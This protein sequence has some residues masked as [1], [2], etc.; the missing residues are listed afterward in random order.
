MQLFSA[1]MDLHL[2]P[3]E[4]RFLTVFLTLSSTN[5]DYH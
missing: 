2:K 5:G 1:K 3:R 4:R